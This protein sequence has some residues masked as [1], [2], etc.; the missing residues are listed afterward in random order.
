MK[1]Y[2]WHEPRRVPFCKWYHCRQYHLAHGNTVGGTFRHMVLLHVVPFCTW[3][4]SARGTILHM[5]PFCTWYHSAH[6][7]IMT[8][9]FDV[10]QTAHKTVLQ[11]D[12]GAVYLFYMESI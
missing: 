3:Y 4:H 5:V 12:F 9:A 6:G 2:W 1:P 8:R 10:E 11:A 7:T